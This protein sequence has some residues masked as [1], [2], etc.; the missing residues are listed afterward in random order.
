MR[1]Q[2]ALVTLLLV[3]EALVGAQQ[4]PRDAPRASEPYTAA[5][6]AILVDVVV[7][8]KRGRPIT[9][10]TKEDFE[11]YENDIPQTVGSFSVVS[12]ASGIGI[13]LR[14][15][16]PGTTTV[17][18]SG[19]SGDA[20]GLPEAD[21]RPPTTAMVF[22][23]LTPEALGLAQTAALAELPMNGRSPGRIAVFSAQPGL[24][25]LQPYTEDLALVRSAVRRVSAVGSAREEAETQRLTQINE[26]LRQLDV[27]S[28]GV[29][30][31]RPAAF[32]PGND[33]SSTAQA[34][35]EAQMANMEMRMI[36]NFETIDR[37]H[38]GFGTASA[39]MTIIQ[40]LTEWQGR[41]TIVYFSEGLPA[42]PA[43][44]AK[45]DSV[46]SAANRANV[47]VY[48]IDAA[49]LRLQST[50][51]ETRREIDLAAE[52]RLRQTTS[53][54]STDGPLMRIVER[55]EDLLRLDPQ[56]GL[57]RL[58]EDTGGFLVRDTNDL[59]SA[60]RRIDEDNK[61][62]YMLTYSPKNEHFDGKFRRIGVKVRRDG[63]QV[64]SR[65][66]YFAVR[67]AVAPL[68]SYEAP[69]I[70]ALDSGK[71]PNAFAI[72]A[73]AMV[74]P[75]PSGKT[76]VPVVVRV[77]TN[78]LSFEVDR[79]KGTYAAQ[80]AVVA[81]IR[82][83]RGEAVLTLSQQYILTG[84]DKELDAAKEGE[85]LFYRQAD[86]PPGTYGLEA[87]VY[88]ALAERASA[89]LSTITVPT[90]SSSRLA[91][92]SLVLVRRSEQVPPTERA[93]N[94]PFYYGNRLLYPNTGEPLRR[95]ADAELMFYISY[96]PVAGDDVGGTVEI[97]NNGRILASTA[98]E[99]P[100]AS[101]AD[102]VQHVGTLPLSGLPE[103]TYE[104]RLR[105]SQG[106]DEQLR[107]AFFTIMQ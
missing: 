79:A 70:A 99:M 17:T 90:V 1:T 54:D 58:A 65:K 25:I 39:L 84:T 55:T 31:D 13:Q 27:L 74:F 49:G 53:R 10:L 18:T 26:R 56:G 40:S 63:A 64:F 5:T 42:S 46:V 48:A 21:E 104:L 19:V 61:F 6:T 105:L 36:R 106:K 14:R 12:R 96:Y 51:G 89:R 44:Q 47:S 60:F 94:L 102:R 57:A 29:G 69:A 24:R 95:G 72:G 16:A 75:E 88:D 76:L 22:D 23:S 11:V 34:I 3:A 87:I 38:R 32:G 8:D 77:R 93:P 62:H 78:Q 103:G 91:A 67:S 43:L 2:T 28:G 33:N 30:V 59:G 4:R 100:P 92:S 66:G 37:D 98:L 68:L 35:V 97:L 80:A 41:K 15:R 20:A 71:P 101:T 81:R 52:E 86:L 50:L 73:A 85:L 45:L 9:D 83:A 82:D 107:T 7:R